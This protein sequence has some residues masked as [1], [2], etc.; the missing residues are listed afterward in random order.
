[1]PP[2]IISA[3]RGL[4]FGP[5]VALVGRLVCVKPLKSCDKRQLHVWQMR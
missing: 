4:T 5:V 2:Q 1:M 3:I